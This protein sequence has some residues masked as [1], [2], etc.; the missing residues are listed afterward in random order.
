MK[1]WGYRVLLFAMLV[2]FTMSCQLW[3]LLT[4]QPPCGPSV[5]SLAERNFE[6]KTVKAGFS[7]LP[8]IPQNTPNTAYW[9][10]G[11][12][13]P[14][15]V[16]LSPVADNLSLGDILRGGEQ[17]RIVWAS[18]D[19]ASFI[20]GAPRQEILNVPGLLNQSVSG[21][22]VIIQ[23]D[24]AAVAWVIR[25]E[26][27]SGEIQDISTPEPEDVLAEVSLL[28]TALSQ[29]G[30]QLKVSVSIVNFGQR[31]IMV[32]SENVTLLASGTV[33]L[34]LTSEPALPREI[35]PGATETFTLIFVR[36]TAS[37]ATLRVFDVEFVLGGE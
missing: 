22:A 16:F 10:D 36:P 18:C 11:T 23:S 5:L 26:L 12:N 3:S 31:T 20:L 25:G 14:Y 34:P 6:I 13:T 29:D 37:E 17:A 21:L 33:A 28:E 15:V 4:Y 27:V 1:S 32:S 30:S 19:S 2:F 35:A 7:A 8:K 9:V 24:P